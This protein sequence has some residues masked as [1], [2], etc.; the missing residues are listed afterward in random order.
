MTKCPAH[1][2]QGGTIGAAMQAAHFF[3]GLPLLIKARPYW[4]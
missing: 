4:P 3:G 1:A 2:Q